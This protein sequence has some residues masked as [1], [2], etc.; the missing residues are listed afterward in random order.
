LHA[1][2]KQKILHQK[3]LYSLR[4]ESIQVYVHLFSSIIMMTE[5]KSFRNKFLIRKQT[6]LERKILEYISEKQ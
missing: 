5:K 2:Q 3:S 6:F 1:A 4:I